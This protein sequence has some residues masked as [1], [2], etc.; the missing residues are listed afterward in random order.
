[1]R[2]FLGY[3]V[4]LFIFVIFTVVFYCLFLMIGSEV[5]LV[6]GGVGIILTIVYFLC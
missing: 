1:M 2:E 3:F 6:Y 5:I 4:S